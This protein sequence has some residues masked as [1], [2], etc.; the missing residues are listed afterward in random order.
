LTLAYGK[1]VDALRRRYKAWLWD[2]EFR[3]TIGATVQADGIQ[4]H[5]VFVTYKGKRAVVVVNE[6][7]AKEIIAAVNLPNPASLAV[8][9][10]E[11]PDTR[12]ATGSL[13]IPPR[14]VAVLMEL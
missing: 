4:R 14:S 7:S 3:D 12:P 8:V 10:P 5:S 13:R 9:T 1:K 2:G 11:L 6:E